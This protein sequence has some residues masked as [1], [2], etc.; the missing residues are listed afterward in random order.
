M[1]TIIKMHASYVELIGVC[2]VST[3][4]IQIQNG[5]IKLVKGK[6]ELWMKV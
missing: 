1:S 2:G 4:I 6:K 5:I 3:Q